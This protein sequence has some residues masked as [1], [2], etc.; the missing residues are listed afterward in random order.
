[1]FL[2]TSG[3]VFCQQIGLDLFIRHLHSQEDSVTQAAAA[4]ILSRMKK[5]SLSHVYSELHFTCAWISPLFP[6][7]QI[8]GQRERI[9]VSVMRAIA[10]SLPVFMHWFW[11]NAGTFS[12]T[13]AVMCMKERRWYSALM[14]YSDYCKREKEKGKK[15]KSADTKKTQQSVAGWSQSCISDLGFLSQLEI[16]PITHYEK[17]AI[18]C[19]LWCDETLHCFPIGSRMHGQNVCTVFHPV[20]RSLS[21]WRSVYEWKGATWRPEGFCPQIHNTLP[22]RTSAVT[23]KT[24]ENKMNDEWR[25]TWL[26]YIRQL[27]NRSWCVGSRSWVLFPV[28]SIFFPVKMCFYMAFGRRPYPTRPTLYLITCISSM[29]IKKNPRLVYKSQH[30]PI[31]CIYFYFIASQFKQD[32]RV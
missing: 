18:M 28:V 20:Q 13:G 25:L 29:N 5:S 23:L 14:C 12:V 7:R 11:I 6:P 26:G 24:N 27:L 15:R 10:L 32:K 1:M 16:S 3:G 8:S 19:H 30:R 2:S 31:S 22:T 9:S 21:D 17:D 4:G